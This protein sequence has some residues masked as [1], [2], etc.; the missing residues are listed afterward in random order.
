MGPDQ[1][2][3]KSTV[4]SRRDKSA[5]GTRVKFSNRMT[6]LNPDQNACSAEL[7]LI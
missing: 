4:F 2:A 3:S 1:L 6:M 5:S 7:R